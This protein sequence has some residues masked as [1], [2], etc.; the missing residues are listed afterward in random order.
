M[1]LLTRFLN[2][3]FTMMFH[4]QISFGGNL[5]AMQAH[6]DESERLLGA[7]SLERKDLISRLLNSGDPALQARALEYIDLGTE[8]VGSTLI[9]STAVNHGELY[10]MQLALG[11]EKGKRVGFDEF[12]TLLKGGTI[13][14][15]GS[16]DIAVVGERFATTVQQTLRKMNIIDDMGEITDFAKTLGRTQEELDNI[17]AEYKLAG[18]MI[19]KSR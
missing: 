18:E 3:L 13:A 12:S 11:I 6:L 19:K 2:L 14:N 7:T 10:A 17:L 8:A 5:E 15:D 4:Y 9:K 16:P 1:Q